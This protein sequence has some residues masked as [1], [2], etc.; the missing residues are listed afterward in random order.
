MS[1]GQKVN[2]KKRSGERPLTASIPPHLQLSDHSPPNI[3]THMSNWALI[4]LPE[5]TEGIRHEPT[6]ISV[7]STRAL[8]LE[9]DVEADES[10]F[11]PPQGN[12]EFAH[13]HADGSWHINVEESLAEYI[14]DMNWGERHPRFDEGVLEILVYAPRNLEEADL[15]KSLV[16]ESIRYASKGAVRPFGN[17]PSMNEEI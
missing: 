5:T 3:Q 17:Q 7:P 6:R 14:I 12:R 10:G 15:I 2:I 11:M 16:L 8:W 1:S 13:L 4:A 9:E